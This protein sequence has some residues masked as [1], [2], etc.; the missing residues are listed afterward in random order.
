MRLSCPLVNIRP[1]FLIMG[2]GTYGQLTMKRA[3][4]VIQ[5]IW[6]FHLRMRRKLLISG[7]RSSSN[8]I[9]VLSSTLHLQTIQQQQWYSPYLAFSNKAYGTSRLDRL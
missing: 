7:T 8:L 1:R 2:V 3:W 6:E 9:Y 4:R 5:I